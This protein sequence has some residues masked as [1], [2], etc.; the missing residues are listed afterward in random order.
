MFK[1]SFQ[2]K[3]IHQRKEQK[4]KNETLRVTEVPVSCP[5]GEMFEE[6]FQKINE[7]GKPELVAE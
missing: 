5:S 7:L 1:I 3:K 2:G 4:S 6:D